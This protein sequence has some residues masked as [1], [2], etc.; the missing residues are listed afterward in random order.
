MSNNSSNKKYVYYFVFVFIGLAYLIRLLYL[1]VFDQSYELYARNNA[2]HEVTLHPSRG[3]IRDRRG[4]LLVFNDA[5]Y[6]L[7]CIPSK[8]D[9][10]DTVEF[11][12]LLEINRAEFFARFRK[13]QNTKGYAKYKT[14]VFEKQL[15]AQTYAAFQEKLFDFPGFFVETRID[16]RYK[17]L[18]GAHVLGYIGEVV[19]KDIDNSERYYKQGDLIGISGIERAYEKELRGRK[20]VKYILVDNLN[21]EQGRYKNGAFDS[22]PIAGEDLTTT[23]DFRL[24]KLGE[25][26]MVNKIG[27][28]VAI[29]PATGD[30][31]CMVSS[32]TYDPNLFIGRERGNN[33]M[34]LL[35][36]PTKPLFNR[37]IAAPYPPGSIFKI[38]MSLVGQQEGVLTPETMY[39]CF[40]GY[41]NGS[42]KVGCHPHGSPLD[43]RGAVQISCNAYFCHVFKTV[44]DNKK[45]RYVEDAFIQWTKHINSFGIG[46]RLGI[47]L[48]NVFPGLVPKVTMYDKVYGRHH[49]KASTVISLA[50]GQGELG[51]TP[52]QMANVSAILAN[53]GY[54]I[55]PHIAK[56]IGK[57]KK[58]ITKFTQKHYTTVDPSYY[59]V[60]IQGMLDV[61]KGGTG[62]I[63]Q[64]PG[65]EVCGKTGTA[66]NPHGKDHSVFIAFAPKDNPK[67]A[68][69]VV[70]EN[71]GF[72]ATWAAPMA[73]LIMEKYLTDTFK[74]Q[75]VYENMIKGNLMPASKEVLEKQK[76]QKDSLDNIKKIKLKNLKNKKKAEAKKEEQV[77]DN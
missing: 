5:I 62:I 51:I 65:I 32:P 4:E 9:G 49:W 21:R 73:S 55:D 38:V 44:I 64:I 42:N 75:Y 40:G 29:E 45:Y 28:I 50:I 48:P 41:N 58:P 66:Q 15:S 72:G 14:Q 57:S 46:I 2:L 20:G 13:M 61:V 71:A 74:R 6:D 67:I 24:Q 10:L 56:Y 8:I 52:L 68:I 69:A 43:L 31:L 23:L 54:Y 7:M 25:E 60:V 3:L 47:E 63:A 27:S 36:N 59:D 12:N 18:N 77:T 30:V 70:V 17:F 1:Q 33:Y 22:L 53:R 34:K 35:K 11:C 26:L 19:D 39:S 37:P 16:R 76:A